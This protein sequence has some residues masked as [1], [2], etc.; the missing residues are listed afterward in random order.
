MSVDDAFDADVA[1]VGM[2]GRFP[3]ARDVDAF[4]KNLREGV[5]SIRSQ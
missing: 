5:E 3:G 1:V 4:W 2:A